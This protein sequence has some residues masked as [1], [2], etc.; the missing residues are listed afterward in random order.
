M[1]DRFVFTFYN[2]WKQL[3]GGYNWYTFTL[4]DIH[5]EYDK[6]HYAYEVAFTLLGLGF[7]LRYNTK[8]SDEVYAE[9]E[10]ITDEAVKEFLRNK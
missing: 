3:Q 4:C 7:V 2:D 6:M 8:K 9:Y 1:K 10:K 5:F